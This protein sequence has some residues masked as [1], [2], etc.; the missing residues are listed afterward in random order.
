MSRDHWG[1]C[2]CPPGQAR[3]RDAA[4]GLGPGMLLGKDPSPSWSQQ[5]ESS[6]CPHP[7]GNGGPGAC[8]QPQGSR[9]KWMERVRGTLIATCLQVIHSSARA[10][11]RRCPKEGGHY[12]SSSPMPS[13]A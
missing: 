10:L 8:P 1:S 13:K 3:L 7:K 2:Q 4:P 9:G 12:R 11:G 6:S 5:Q